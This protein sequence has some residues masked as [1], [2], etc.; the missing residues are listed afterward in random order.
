[1]EN[2]QICIDKT[3]NDW[4]TKYCT[5]SIP[6]PFSSQQSV[7]QVRIHPEH[8]CRYTGEYCRCLDIT[9]QHFGT[10]KRSAAGM[11]AVNLKTGFVKA[12][13]W[14]ESFSSAFAISMYG[15]S[16]HFLIF[17]LIFLLLCIPSCSRDANKEIQERKTKWDTKRE[18]HTDVRCAAT[19]VYWLN[20]ISWFKYV[21][22]FSSL[23]KCP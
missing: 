2:L 13:F 10:S 1:M 4:I 14:G 23:F 12:T 17:V 11:V 6:V 18:L 22:F 16:C 5:W 8:T 3:A 15:S 20:T 19:N 7:E 21:L 9:F